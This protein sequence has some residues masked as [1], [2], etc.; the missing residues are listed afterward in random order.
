MTLNIF[1]S[2]ECPK[3]SEKQYFDF[4][5]LMYYPVILIYRL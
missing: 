4:V 2:L 1:Y 5:D 3:C